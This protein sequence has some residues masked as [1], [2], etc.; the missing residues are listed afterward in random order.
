MPP[1]IPS[2]FGASLKMGR[3]ETADEGPEKMK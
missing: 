1:A 3:G 2:W